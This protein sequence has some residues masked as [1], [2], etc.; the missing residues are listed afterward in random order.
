MEHLYQWAQ[1][2]AA[3]MSIVSFVVV[4]LLGLAVGKAQKIGFAISQ[5]VRHVLGKKVEEKLEEVVDG[6]DK[7]MHSDNTEQDNGKLS[8]ILIIGFL[9]FGTAQLSQAADKFA[10]FGNFLSPI[11]SLLKTGTWV[12]KPTV[13]VSA[14]SVDKKGFVQPFSAAGA[15]LS[16][17]REIHMGV[18]KTTFEVD[19]DIISLQGNGFGLALLVGAFDGTC[20]GGVYDFKAKSGL[21]LINYSVSLFK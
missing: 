4:F 19:L 20:I 6:I 12:F 15:G 14:M 1:S 21:F 8:K 2:H 16:F 7:G 5:F 10:G 3:I 18:T 17:Q 13:T 9:I 11:D